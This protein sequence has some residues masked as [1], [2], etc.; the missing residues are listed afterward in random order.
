MPSPALIV[1]GVI[2][3]VGAGFAF[4]QVRDLRDFHVDN[5]LSPRLV[6]LRPLLGRATA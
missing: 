5:I 6:C 1:G 3:A 4:K 2:I